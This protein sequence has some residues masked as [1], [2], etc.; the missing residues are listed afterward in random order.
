MYALIDEY[1]IPI[2]AE[3]IH[4]TNKPYVAVLTFDAWE[5]DKDRFQMGM[6]LAMDRG[7]L[8]DMKAIVNY[9]SLTGT[10]VIPQITSPDKPPYRFAFALDEKGIVFID[11]TGFAETV[12]ARIREKR[13]W[14]LPSLER[15]LYDFLEE[16]IAK[17]VAFLSEYEKELNILEDQILT[18]DGESCT[19]R[20]N[21][22]RGELL[23]LRSYYTELMDLSQELEENENGFFAEDNLRYFRLF[24]QRLERLSGQVLSLRDYTAQL[25]DLLQTQIDVR[26]NRIMAFLTIVTTVFT[27][28]TLITGWY[29]MNFVY[30]PELNKPWAYP[31]VILISAGIVAG[32]L[33]MFRKKKWL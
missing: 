13:R 30:M 16:L 27:P 24:T 3:E 23:D 6:D 19:V 33:W 4:G 31:L 10:F 20:I 14:K 8:Y 12:I 32:L 26:Q 29:G 21:D 17:D 11:D 28:L 1:L 2:Q 18:G 9:D 15:F 25:R 7:Q 22:I 5:K